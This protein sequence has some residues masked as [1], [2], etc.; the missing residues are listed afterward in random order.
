MECPD[1]ITRLQFGHVA[2]RFAASKVVAI[3]FGL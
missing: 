2:S 3:F 1:P